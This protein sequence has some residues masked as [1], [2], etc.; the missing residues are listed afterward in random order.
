MNKDTIQSENTSEQSSGEDLFKNFSSSPMDDNKPSTNSIALTTM[1]EPDTEGF[2]STDQLDAA[3]NNGSG[4][5]PENAPLK[6]GLSAPSKMV[7]KGS[8]KPTSIEAKRFT[9]LP[10]VSPS[11]SAPE[12]ND[13]PRAAR[14]PSA[15]TV[16]PDKK[17]IKIVGSIST[18]NASVGQILQEARV[19]LELGLTQVEQQ[20]RI[21]RSFL[22]AVERDDLKNLPAMC[23]VSA[24][25]KTLC[26]LYRI[27]A[28]TSSALLA[29]LKA[30][31]GERSVPSELLQSLENDKHINFAEEAKLK[32]FATFVIV[33]IVISATIGFVY[34]IWP[35]EEKGYT[36]I[37]TQNTGPISSDE[38]NTSIYFD[39][40]ELEKL[41]PNIYIDMT[42]LT[43]ED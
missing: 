7:L 14:A 21:K 11:K 10:R 39:E 25:I 38:D 24:Y 2:I 22:E 6:S 37:K 42:T 27:D 15:L 31:K 4:P 33:L 41:I 3:F 43:I 8:A 28:E 17:S 36:E 9:E 35:T 19:C 26:Q 30:K 5:S 13:S 34:N 29:S 1:L 16:Q 18:E 23:Y 32:K 40:K 20:T 12:I